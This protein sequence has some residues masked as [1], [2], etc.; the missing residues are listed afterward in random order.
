M[1][2]TPNPTS[3]L[4]FRHH[5]HGATDAE[6]TK[7]LSRI[8][9]A[10]VRGVPLDDLPEIIDTA[11]ELVLWQLARQ[12]H[13]RQT[14]D[15]KPGV[16]PIRPKREPQYAD[17]LIARALRDADAEGA[18]WTPVLDALAGSM[19]WETIAENE[20]AFD[21]RILPSE[22]ERARMLA[23]WVSSTTDP[24]ALRSLLQ[25]R[26]EAIHYV[27]ADCAR[28]LDAELAN[29]L[30]L[31]PEIAERVATNSTLSPDAARI[32]IERAYR[33][34]RAVV[35]NGKN[36][37]SPTEDGKRRILQ[38]LLR[39]G[40][41]LPAGVVDEIMDLAR[42][43]IDFIVRENA[44]LI[45]TSDRS[46]SA[47]RLEEL[48]QRAGPQ[49]AAGIVVHPNCPEELWK[50]LV[51]EPVAFE[52]TRVATQ[53]P[54]DRVAYIYEAWKHS[55]WPVAILQG[56]LRQQHS[57]PEIW[58]E[59][60]AHAQKDPQNRPKLLRALADQPR[61]RQDDEI[62]AVLR[63]TGM[64]EVIAMLL[65]DRQP[66]EFEPL[67]LHLLGF[68][69]EFALDLLDRSGVPPGTPFPHKLATRLL[70]S[71]NDRARLLGITLI[72]EFKKAE[73]TPPA[74]SKDATSISRSQKSRRTSR[75]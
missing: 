47:E 43:S 34:W 19:A 55:S 18:V 62:R 54:P 7:L 14:P 39:N 56:L 65:A 8:L 59:A 70:E 10:H 22:Y 29:D 28:I 2:N 36:L 69:P 25:F 33:M 63:E 20:V 61:A 38:T 52:S 26:A 30:I 67:M 51:N 32:L 53:L 3:T 41:S 13:E 75:H 57:T 9:D 68:D 49:C 71:G 66:D 24:V 1:T 17:R 6:T 35:D 40:F 21:G 31:T 45:L 4:P 5:L 37:I 42:T 46:L 60:L 48:S 73:N 74:L 64:P 16:F 72:S 15:A 44:G 27:V 12:L 58:K 23:S 11:N 50:R